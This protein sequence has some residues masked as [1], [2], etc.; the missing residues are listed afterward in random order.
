MFKIQCDKNFIDKLQNFFIY[1]KTPVEINCF[2]QQDCD[3]CILRDEFFPKDFSPSSKYILINSDDKN[4]L[5]RIK[6]F[7][8]NIVSCGLSTRSTATLSSISDDN[9]VICLQRRI[10]D[11]YGKTVPQLEFPIKL[12]SLYLDDI[13]VIMI[14]ISALICGVDISVLSKINL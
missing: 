7:R 6:S 1:L 13:S 14:A 3:I 8:S 10:T 5:N 11:L 2:L 12:S 4:L 9:K